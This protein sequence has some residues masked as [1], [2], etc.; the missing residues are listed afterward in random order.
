MLEPELRDQ[1]EAFICGRISL[2]QL[3]VW[4]TPRCRNPSRI[5]C[6]V[7]CQVLMALQHIGDGVEPIEEEEDLKAQLSVYL[8]ERETT[9]VSRTLRV[10]WA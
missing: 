8:I 5:E 2:H 4:L 9:S 10:R 3:Y 1:L 7:D 6:Q